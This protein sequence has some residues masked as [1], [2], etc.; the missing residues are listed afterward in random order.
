MN[1]GE[2]NLTPY[3]LI[4]KRKN[5]IMEEESKDIDWD[6]VEDSMINQWYFVQKI[7]GQMIPGYFPY[8][9]Y[10]GLLDCLHNDPNFK[11]KDDD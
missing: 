9:T 7:M 3:E 4:Q 5:K 2:E 8:F 10:E 1:K 11:K 6:S